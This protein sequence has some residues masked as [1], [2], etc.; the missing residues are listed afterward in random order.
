MFL[1]RFLFN[2]YSFLSFMQVNLGQH[3][4]WRTPISDLSLVHQHNEIHIGHRVDSVGN[5]EN[6]TPEEPSPDGLLDELIRSW[7]HIGRCLVQ[8][9]NLVL[10]QQSSGH[11]LTINR[12][13]LLTDSRN[14]RFQQ[15][16]RYRLAADPLG[17]IVCSNCRVG[18]SH[19]K[20]GVSLITRMESTRRPAA[21]P[22][23]LPPNI[24]LR[25]VEWGPDDLIGTVSAT[26]RGPPI[27]WGILRT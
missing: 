2:I 10:S 15:C 11:P 16:N 26:S 27:T 22:L 3:F 1:I 19:S 20:S 24:Y 12:K 7:I 23:P 13:R 25:V 18:D 17:T 6:R 21:S 14:P 4:S 5:R 8:K 9:E